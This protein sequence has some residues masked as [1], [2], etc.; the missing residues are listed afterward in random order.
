MPWPSQA[1][2]R[3]ASMRLAPADRARAPLPHEP[4]LA[5]LRGAPAPPRQLGEAAQPR[6]EPDAPAAAAPGLRPRALP[7]VLPSATLS[8]AVLQRKG[9]FRST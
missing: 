3:A 2:D 5:A 4:P 7:P 9:R 8:G 6:L 1:A